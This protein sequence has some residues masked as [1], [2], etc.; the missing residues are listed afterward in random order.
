MSTWSH[1]ANAKHI[2]RIIAHVRAHPAAWAN[3]TA[4]AWSA[5]RRARNAVWNA[6]WSDAAEAAW[7]AAKGSARLAIFALVAW[8]RASGLMDLPAEQV[9]VLAL[10]GD[11]AAMLIYPAV[12]AMETTQELA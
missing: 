11:Q 6:A 8:D 10:L 1:L 7:S 9:K 3:A 2:D 12:A 5:A 4:A